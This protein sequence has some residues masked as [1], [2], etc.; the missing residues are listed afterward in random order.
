MPVSL[1][2]IAA[3]EVHALASEEEQRIM[4]MALALAAQQP[5]D[6]AGA[7]GLINLRRG[8]F[9][10]KGRSSY[11]RSQLVWLG[12][13]AAALLMLLIGALWM[14]RNDLE[15]QR[16]AMRA[17]VAKETKQVF[18]ASLYKAADIKKRAAGAGAE[19]ASVA[20]KVSAYEQL[21]QIVDAIGRGT[22]LSLT[23]YEVD[24]SRKIVQLRGTTSSPQAV[25]QIV[26]D[27][28]K[29]ECVKNIKKDKLQVKNENTVNFELQIATSCS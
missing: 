29:V 14:Q 2:T 25:D 18:G 19:A 5:L 1:M 6:R 15:A 8:P 9:A 12:A 28:E 16:E 4:P 26:V 10:Y 17:A 23:R 24:V 27:L 13:A 3:P 7:A 20:P 21:F 22:E 11:V